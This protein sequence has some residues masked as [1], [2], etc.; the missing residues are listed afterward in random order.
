[1]SHSDGKTDEKQK[2]EEN[3]KITAIF[4]NIMPIARFS[5]IVQ[6]YFVSTSVKDFSKP[7]AKLMD[8]DCDDKTVKGKFGSMATSTLT[9]ML[10]SKIPVACFPNILEAF[11]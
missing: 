6:S 11:F 1:M 3:W 8:R 4:I 9:S 10:N 2:K 5:N 7:D